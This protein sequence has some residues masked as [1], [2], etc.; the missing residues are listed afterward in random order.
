MEGERKFR[1][2]SASRPKALLG[3]RVLHKRHSRCFIAFS[4]PGFYAVVFALHAAREWWRCRGLLSERGGRSKSDQITSVST[5]SHVVIHMHSRLGD[6]S[7]KFVHHNG[8]RSRLSHGGLKILA[9]EFAGQSLQ[10]SAKTRQY[11]T[12]NRRVHRC[13]SPLFLL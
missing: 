1:R 11:C 7:S 3:G 8:R 12:M 2:I 6:H 5:S 13:A 4:P 9:L 10:R